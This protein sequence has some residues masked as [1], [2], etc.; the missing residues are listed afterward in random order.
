MH[1]LKYQT[2]YSLFVYRFLFDTSGMDVFALYLTASNIQCTFSNTRNISLSLSFHSIFLGYL[3][4]GPVCISALLHTQPNSFLANILNHLRL[5]T[6][7]ILLT[8]TATTA[9]CLD[10]LL[11][12]PT[13][14]TQFA[15]VDTRSSLYSLGADSQKTPFATLLLLLHYV[16]RS[17]VSCVRA[18][19]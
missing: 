1:F 13:P 3:W 2:K 18:I 7:S 6:L 11:Q 15:F 4:D 19:T 8:T 14:G 10:S 17:S 16:T 5:P 9:N 12:L